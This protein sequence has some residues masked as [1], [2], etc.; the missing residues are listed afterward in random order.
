MPINSVSITVTTTNTLL[1][2]EARG[3]RMVVFSNETGNQLHIGGPGMT[4]TDG[5][6]LDHKES[7]VIQQSHENDFT[8]S[9]A[10]YGRTDSSSG[11]CIVTWSTEDST[12]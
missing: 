9:H 5:I 12:D 2:A 4:A 3:R 1:L 7:L 8:P 10:W 6:P 11:P